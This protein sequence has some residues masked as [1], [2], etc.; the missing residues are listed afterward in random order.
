[1]PEKP[2]KKSA[3]QKKRGTKRRGKRASGFAAALRDEL[4]RIEPA[5]DGGF[6]GLLADALA[7]FSGLT[8]RLAK[9]GSQFGRDGSST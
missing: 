4:L 7:A 8:F 9:S 5:G 2:K 6:E 3:S 1:M